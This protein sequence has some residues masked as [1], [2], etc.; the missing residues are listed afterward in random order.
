MLLYNVTVTIDPEI[1]LEWLTW[2]KEHHIPEV[3]ASGCFTTNRVCK[4]IHPEP[5][6]GQTYAFQYTCHDQETLDRYFHEFAPALQKKHA[7][8]YHERFVAFRTV[9]EIL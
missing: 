6:M 3:L 8:R 5:E 4:L 2:M 7:E 1:Q 9:L